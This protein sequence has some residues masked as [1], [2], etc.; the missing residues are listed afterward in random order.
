MRVELKIGLVGLALFL[1]G[2]FLA[3]YPET[4][5][6]T[7]VVPREELLVSDKVYVKPGYET[8][9][10][11]SVPSG[12]S[13]PRLVVK[14]DVYSGGNKD[15]E[16]VVKNAAGQ[17]I[18]KERVAGYVERTIPLPGPG[19]YR[20]SLSNWFSLVTGKEAYLEAKLLYNQAVL[21]STT[22]E[23]QT[24]SDLI[25]L[26]IGLLTLAAIIALV[27]TIHRSAKAFKEG[28]QGA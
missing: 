1:I 27:R 5:K 15:L 13:S 10:D 18:Y 12:A 19:Q 20:L 16:L 9:W 21:K 11:F 26:G 24:A 28:L 22:E 23:R 3:A 8:Y 7:V 4:A 2:A 14:L 6:H 17:S 25:E